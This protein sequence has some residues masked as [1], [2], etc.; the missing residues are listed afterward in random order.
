MKITNVIFEEINDLL[1]WKIIDKLTCF[2]K[3]Q[4]KAL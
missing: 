2:S 3:E 4:M 1:D